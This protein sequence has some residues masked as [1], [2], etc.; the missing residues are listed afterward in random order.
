MNKKIV[1]K[2]SKKKVLFICTYNSARSQ[3]AEGLLNTLYGDKYKAF[4]AGIKKTS[5]N[6]YA[7]EVMKE[8][9]V[10]LSKHYS[11]NIDEF[12]FITFDYVVTV[13]DNTKESCPFFPGKK[14]LHRN[15]E[16]PANF[17]GE[18]EET[19][20]VFRKV[21]D[22]IKVWIINNFDKN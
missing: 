15:F 7:F 5:V 17:N 13:C 22:E 14:I 18:I 11:K 2:N 16:D 6:P 20:V 19:L 9:G 8:I 12:Q 10:D 1:E 21:R 3:M 4:S